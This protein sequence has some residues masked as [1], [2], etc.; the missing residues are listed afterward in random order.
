MRARWRCT[1][2]SDSVSS[3]RRVKAAAAT[4]WAFRSLRAALP[5]SLPVSAAGLCPDAGSPDAGSLAAVCLP[6][7]S[8]DALSGADCFAF[9]A[10]TLL[11]FRT[12]ASSTDGCSELS[13]SVP[14]EPAAGPGRRDTDALPDCFCGGAAFETFPDR[15]RPEF[16]VGD[17]PASVTW[18]GN[19]LSMPT[20]RPDAASCAAREPVC[21]VCYSASLRRKHRT[22]KK[23][24]L[25]QPLTSNFV[26]A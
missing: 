14:L 13:E 11:D 6:G 15:R 23:S 12:P 2:S 3:E 17:V 18:S 9:R 1:A 10:S 21:C 7:C 25:A 24:S 19:P 16:F 5:C 26:M 8:R 20:M 22:S 4:C